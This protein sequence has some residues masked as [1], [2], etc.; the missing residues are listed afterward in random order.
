MAM[1]MRATCSIGVEEGSADDEGASA[2]ERRL[3]ATGAEEAMWVGADLS[4]VP[5]EGEED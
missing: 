2:V 3:Q 5:V 4:Q 1:L